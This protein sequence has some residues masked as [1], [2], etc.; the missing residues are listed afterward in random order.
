MASID[1][2]IDEYRTS[3][4]M[5]AFAVG[6]YHEQ[7]RE[8][9][10]AYAQARQDGAIR[11]TILG[12]PEERCHFFGDQLE[13][14]TSVMTIATVWRMS[15][16]RYTLLCV[17]A[18]LRRCTVALEELGVWVPQIRDRTTIRQL[19]DIDE[20]WEQGEAGRSRAELRAV[21]PDETPTRIVHNGKYIQIGGF[22]TRE[23]ADWA[24]QVDA[25]VR[26]QLEEAGTPI[27]RVDESLAD[28]FTRQPPGG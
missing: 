14:A 26:K 3:A 11:N 19:R 24:A 27:A 15:M 2:G 10:A 13:K 1:P 6:L 22:D 4:A 25:A 16:A 12:A 18:Q 5:W 8:A 20:C 7:L 28:F 21:M 17:A 9:V 23:I